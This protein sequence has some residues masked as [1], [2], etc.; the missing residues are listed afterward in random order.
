MRWLL[1]L[2]VV[3]PLAELYLLLAIGQW[4]GFW[5]TIGL[6][7]VTAI[8]GSA[9]AKREGLRV[10]FAWREALARA[11]PPEQGV[12]DG[13]LVLLGG[14]LLITPG[15]MT[16]AVGFALLIPWSRHKIADRIR[17]EIDRRLESGAVRV[18]EVHS[19]GGGPLGGA[20]G[21]FTDRAP[22]GEDV[23]PRVGASVV[24]TRGESVD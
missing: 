5:P 4:I 15:V 24:E 6:T 2:F 19:H 11:A 21:P 20:A 9:L 22:F 16:D 7:L 1:L 12:V 23:R 13:V 8:A 18:V 3:V 10:W 17:A 14:A